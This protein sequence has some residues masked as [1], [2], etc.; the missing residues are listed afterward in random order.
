MPVWVQEALKQGGLFAV[1]V[2]CVVVAVASFRIFYGMWKD[3]RKR[4]SDR[5]DAMQVQAAAGAKA[6]A[7][8]ASA[9]NRQADVIEGHTH[10]LQRQREEQ[11]R[12]RLEQQKKGA[13]NG[14]GE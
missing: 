6:N 12:R 11:L 13:G 8:L 9:M 2:I 3:E 10:E 5:E 7:D 4:N 14:S 1:A